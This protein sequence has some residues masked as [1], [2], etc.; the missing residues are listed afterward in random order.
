MANLPADFTNL[1]P[2]AGSKKSKKSS[3]KG[4]AGLTLLGLIGIF[5]ALAI[6]GCALALKA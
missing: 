6:V 3:G 2:F 4:S 1:S 5:A